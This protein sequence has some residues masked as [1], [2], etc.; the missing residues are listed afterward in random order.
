M[1]N[2]TDQYNDAFATL[3]QRCRTLGDCCGTSMATARSRRHRLRMSRCC[4]GSPPSRCDTG[5]SRRHARPQEPS[6][7]SSRLCLPEHSSYSWTS[8]R[9]CPRWIDRR[10]GVHAR[11]ADRTRVCCR[12]PC[13]RVGPDQIARQLEPFVRSTPAQIEQT[14]AVIRWTHADLLRS[15]NDNATLEQFGEKLSQAYEE[16]NLLFRLSRLLGCVSDPA[17][18]V[19]TFC[20]QVQ[21]IMP[22]SWLAVRFD[23]RHTELRDVGDETDPRGQAPCDA[24]AIDTAAIKLVQG[25]G[26]DD[27]TRVLRPV[28]ARWPMSPAPRCWAEPITFDG[29]SI[30]GYSLATSAAPIRKSAAKKRSSSTPPRRSWA[31]STKTRR[32]SRNSAACSWGLKAMTAAIDAKTLH[33]RSLRTSRPCGFTPGAGHRHERRRSRALPHRRPGARHRQ[34]RH[35]RSGLVQNGRLTE[36]EFE[37]IKKHPVIGYQILRDIPLM[38]EHPPRR[39]ASPRAIQWPRL[40]AQPGRRGNPPD[41]ADDR[42]GRHVRC[43]EFDAFL[44]PAMPRE[45]VLQEIHSFAG[46][47]IRPAVSGHFRATRFRRVRLHAESAADDGKRRGMRSPAALRCVFQLVPHRVPQELSARSQASSD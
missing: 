41:R 26:E 31:F 42:L 25:W 36:G 44:P 24:S 4:R 43:D 34:D 28:K 18:L 37:I 5:W 32:D 15:A 39:S 40:S 2:R 3:A 23:P 11:G 21:E 12:L 17:G 46:S 14:A 9:C 45:K 1:S 16:T 8:G 13:R 33:L 30:G 38:Q 10:V 27:W 6:T 47:P 19:N 29:R 35:P 22:F 20:Q 7:S